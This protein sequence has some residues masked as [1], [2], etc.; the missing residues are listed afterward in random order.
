MNN[1]LVWKIVSWIDGFR[2]VEF[3]EIFGLYQGKCVYLVLRSKSL[4]LY[5]KFGSQGDAHISKSQI[6]CVVAMFLATIVAFHYWLVWNCR[7]NLEQLNID[8]NLQIVVADKDDILEVDWSSLF[9]HMFSCVQYFQHFWI[10]SY[11][12]SLPLCL[13]HSCCQQCDPEYQ[14]HSYHCCQDICKVN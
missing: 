8:P 3:E 10:L 4:W 6:I 12:L 7:I 13:Q 11:P 5:H 9:L 14:D 1:K 2:L